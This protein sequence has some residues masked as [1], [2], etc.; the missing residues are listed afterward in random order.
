M[1]SKQ[2][3]VAQAIDCFSKADY[4][5]GLSADSAWVGIYQTLLWYERVGLPEHPFL[6]HI[7]D[8][9]MLRPS[10]SRG[11][12]G[13]GKFSIWPQRAATFEAYL[14]KQLGRIADD[15]PA[16]V[17]RLMKTPKMRRLQRQNPLGTAFA[18][19]AGHVLERFGSSGVTYGLEVSAR[20]IFPG[21]PM[22]GRSGGAKIDLVA[23]K[24]TLP[25]AFISCKWSLRHDRINDITSEC[26]DYKSA[27]MRLRIP[28]RYY[29]LTNEFEP[30][31]LL[32]LLLDPCIDG[33]VHVHKRAVIDVCKMDG[34]L[35][36]M[37]DLTE[38]FS[39]TK[40]W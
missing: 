16:M 25:A 38:F 30:A 34:R 36:A 35:A 33:L 8:S 9:N 40:K 23:S 32:K 14:A 19:I 26:P 37:L 3:T 24:G 21:I 20:E 17:D 2:E 27:A 22:P 4:P 5:G 10:K 39:V 13:A 15:L 29:V 31:R 7:I 28:L 6:P 1:P 11:G 12:R 18:G